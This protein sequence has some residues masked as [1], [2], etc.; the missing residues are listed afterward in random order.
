M[1]TTL[2]LLFF[3]YVVLF[4]LSVFLRDNSI[5]DIFWGSW[6]VII[7]L[8]SF[9]TLENPN[10]TQIFVTGFITFWWLRLTYHI[11]RKKLSHSWEDARYAKWR[12]QWKYFYI[13]SF[14]QVYLFQWFLMCL[15]ATPI[16]LINLNLL[17]SNNYI[18]VIVW[19]AIAIFGLIYEIIADSQLKQFIKTKKKWEI[20]T[21]WLRKYSRYP[22]YFGESIFW[23]GI[24]IIALQ[25]HVFALLWWWV[26]TFLLLYVSWV[27]MLEARYAWDKN[28]EKY[29]ER[30]P[31]FL[32]K[33]S[34][35]LWKK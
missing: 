4:L 21:S 33:I 34:L 25:V 28:Y 1:L 10:L 6:F 35:L 3:A 11:G 22:Q 18:L 14:F 31:K 16:F 27:P 13:R 7:A 15:I 29:S 9:F 20:L 24:S 32:P 19:W 30:V 8:S 17:L 23:L 5:A 2:I 12:K 26:I